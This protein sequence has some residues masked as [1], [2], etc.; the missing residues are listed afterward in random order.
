MSV[1]RKFCVLWLFAKLISVTGEPDGLLHRADG[2]EPDNQNSPRINATLLS[3]VRNEELKGMVEAM[4]DLERTWNH[5]FNYPWTFFNDV[6][7]TAEF[8]KQT[9]AVTKAKCNYGIDFV[10][11]VVASKLTEITRT[12]CKRTLGSTLLDQQCLVPRIRQNARRA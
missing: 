12:N 9:Q 6:P 11:F 8:K 7:F 3:L 5:K 10:P 4:I 2:Y 1:S